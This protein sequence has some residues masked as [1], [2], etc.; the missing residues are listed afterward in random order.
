MSYNPY[1]NALHTAAD[2]IANILRRQC[3]KYSAEL[4]ARA[5]QRFSSESS[6]RG[7]SQVQRRNNNHRG[8]GSHKNKRHLL[9]PNSPSSTEQFMSHEGGGGGEEANL[10]VALPCP[11]TIDPEVWKELPRDLQEEAVRSLK[12]ELDRRLLK[13]SSPLH[14][15]AESDVSLDSGFY[16]S[17]AESNVVAAVDQNNNN[18]DHLPTVEATI[19]STPREEKEGGVDLIGGAPTA[20]LDDYGEDFAQIGNGGPAAVKQFEFGGAYQ[21]EVWREK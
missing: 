14:Y 15:D 20:S 21:F 19:V 6:Q 7:S 2:T 8:G 18:L 11:P 1:F 13:Q 10:V 9:S 12:V 5:S 4:G 3:L 17:S 16:P